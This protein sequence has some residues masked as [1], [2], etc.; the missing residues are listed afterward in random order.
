MSTQTLC[1]V[2]GKPTNGYK[3]C[4]TTWIPCALPPRPG[5]NPRFYQWFIE[6]RLLVPILGDIS[7]DPYMPDLC[8]KCGDRLLK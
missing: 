7:M 5:F 4:R 3:P 8:K 2:C 6:T 1:D